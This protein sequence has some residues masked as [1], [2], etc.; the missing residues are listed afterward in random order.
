M[1][2]LDKI[3]DVGFRDSGRGVRAFAL[4]ASVVA[5]HGLRCMVQKLNSQKEFLSQGST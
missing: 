2:P 1:E 4:H 3:P 5:C